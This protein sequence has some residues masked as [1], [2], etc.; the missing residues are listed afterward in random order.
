[1]SDEKCPGESDT[2]FPEQETTNEQ[3]LNDLFPEEVVV[4]DDTAEPVESETVPQPSDTGILAELKFLMTTLTKD[5]ETKLKYDSAKQKQIDTLYHENQQY[6]DGIIRRFQTAMILAVIEQIDEASRQIAYFENAGFSEVNFQKI[7][8]SYRDIALSF[9][10]MLLE[11]FNVENYRCQAGDQFDPK[12]QRSLKTVATDNPDLNK[13]VKQSL[14]FGYQS[15]EGQV[16]RPEL[17]E[18]WVYDKSLADIS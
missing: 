7:L 3:G 2:H 11:K 14:R 5:F 9:Q 18:V 12:R 8:K 13:L 4:T 10:D 15:D 17:V 16:L 6:R 1:M